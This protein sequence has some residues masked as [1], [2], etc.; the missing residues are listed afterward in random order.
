MAEWPASGNTDW[1][2]KMLAYLAV[3]HNTDGT[4]DITGSSV[5]VV[6]TQ[7]GAV[8]TGTTQ[9]PFDDSIPQKTEGDEYMT[10]AITPTSATNELIIEVTWSGAHTGAG[11]I[12]GIA[13]FQDSITNAL[14]TGL[15]TEAVGGSQMRTITFKH[16][17][18]A[19]TTNQ[20]TF[21]VRTGGHIGG[22]TTFNGQL[23]GRIYGGVMASSITITEIKV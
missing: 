14:A 9:I 21:K 23:S 3:E 12:I 15:H 4:H 8:A 11:A 22:T 19:G 2:T 16:K 5:Q 10:L 18:T 7:T 1:N 20:I 13:L 6:N 17:M